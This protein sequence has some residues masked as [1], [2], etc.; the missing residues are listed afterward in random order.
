MAQRQQRTVKRVRFEIEQAGL[1][2]RAAGPDGLAGT[3]FA[4]GGF[5][6]GLLPGEAGFLLFVRAQALGQG[7]DHVQVPQDDTDDS[8]SR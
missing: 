1:I 3:G 4:F 6:F 5:E 2:H 7:A 8:S